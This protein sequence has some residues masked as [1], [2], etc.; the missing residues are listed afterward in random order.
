MTKNQINN[1]KLLQILIDLINNKNGEYLLI[2][3]IILIILHFLPGYIFLNTNI[4]EITK[5][6]GF[7]IITYSLIFII[8][9]FINLGSSISPFPR[10]KRNATLKKNKI[11]SIY[12]HPIYHSLICLSFGIFLIKFS[13]LHLILFICLTINLRIKSKYEEKYLIKKFNDYRSYISSTPAIFNSV[14]FLDWR[15]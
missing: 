5:I 15:E 11:Y 8:M 2:S 1:N 12:R 4:K 3:Q 7:A 10:P 6:F 14:L 13:I 9:A